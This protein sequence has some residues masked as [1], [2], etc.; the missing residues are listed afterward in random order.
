MIGDGIAI[1][2]LGNAFITGFTLNDTAV[3]YPTTSGAFDTTHNGYRDVFV[4]RLRCGRFGIRLF[5][6]LSEAIVND[7]G[8][9]TSP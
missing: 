9:L 5:N 8:Y 1:D 4:T 2:T 7:V 3:K 6:T